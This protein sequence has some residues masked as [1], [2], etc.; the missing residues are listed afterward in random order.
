LRN[1]S[2]FYLNDLGIK[3]RSNSYVVYQVMLIMPLN[4]IALIFGAGLYLLW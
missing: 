2:V 1:G 4:G 3:L